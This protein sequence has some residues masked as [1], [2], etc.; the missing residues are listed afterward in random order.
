[1]GSGRGAGIGRF[2]RHELEPRGRVARAVTDPIVPLTAR[3]GG[4][5]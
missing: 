5:A 3:H 1:M 2:L 4:T